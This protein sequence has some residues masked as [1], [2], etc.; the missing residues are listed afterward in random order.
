MA[1]KSGKNCPRWGRFSLSTPQVR[2]APRMRRT[3]SQPG[4]LSY[5]RHPSLQP[6]LV[7]PCC[8]PPP[9]CLA[10]CPLPPSPSRSASSRCCQARL[11]RPVRVDLEVQG[12]GGVEQ[13]FNGQVRQVGQAMQDL[14]RDG[15][16]VGLQEVQRAVLVLQRQVLGAPWARRVEQAW[17]DIKSM[18]DR[19]PVLHWAPPRIH[20]QV[21]ITG[22]S[23]LLER[24][25]EH[26]C[27]DT[28]RK[29]SRTDC[30]A[31]S[32]RNGRALTAPSGRP[33]TRRRWRPSA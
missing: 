11:P 29:L 19:R 30:G 27:A 16:L 4:H 7:K 12:R 14:P 3:G 31:S 25:V 28:W 6:C 9:R 5:R 20:A 18:L 22:L 33:P 8:W 21:A 1:C 15:L 32:W 24:T 26:A 23:R 10:R 2:Q 17:R 13:H